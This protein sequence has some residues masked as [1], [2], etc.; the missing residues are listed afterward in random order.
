MYSGDFYRQILP[1]MYD[2]SIIDQE[3]F[4]ALMAV[5]DIQ[6][7]LSTRELIELAI[8]WGIAPSASEFWKRHKSRD[9][10]I[11]ALQQKKSD[12]EMQAKLAEQ[13]LV[14]NPGDAER[15]ARKDGR[16]G[17]AGKK[18]RNSLVV[19]GELYTG[20]EILGDIFGSKGEYTD[21]IIYMARRIR[22]DSESAIELVAKKKAATAIA[23]AA[24][25]K[26]RARRNS[27]VGTEERKGEELTH[28]LTAAPLLLPCPCFRTLLHKHSYIYTLHSAQCV[29]TQHN[30]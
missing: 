15:A 18:R 20:K 28:T 7:A 11:R 16:S 29:P 5:R 13:Q 9:E 25:A 30:T 10:L 1:V 14:T 19:L 8:S 23:H 6:T 4:L 3:R 22:M 27:L 26:A 21:G 17:S 24:R 2:A 12:M